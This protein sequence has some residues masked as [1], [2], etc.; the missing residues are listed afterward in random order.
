MNAATDTLCADAL[1]AG[2]AVA[3]ESW[4]RRCQERFEEQANRQLPPSSREPE[5]LLE[6]QFLGWFGFSGF[7]HSTLS[8]AVW[9]ALPVHAW[10][11]ARARADEGRSSPCQ[12]LF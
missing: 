5:R 6:T 10:A 2:S 4:M 12:A 7:S 1:A 11:A 8:W 9:A 3:L